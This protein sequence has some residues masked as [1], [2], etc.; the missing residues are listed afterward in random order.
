M[1]AEKLNPMAFLSA[2]QKT[3]AKDMYTSS[4]NLMKAWKQ[5]G[6]VIRASH[7]Y[8]I[9]KAHGEAGQYKGL[10]SLFFS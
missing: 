9:L 4:M 1:E 2:V 10:C 8:P 6:G 3:I 5:L 7:F